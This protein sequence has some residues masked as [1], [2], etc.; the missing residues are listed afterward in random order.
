MEENSATENAPAANFSIA[1]M[2]D[3]GLRFAGEP[4]AVR[5]MNYLHEESKRYSR[6]L[7][8]KT[9]HDTAVNAIAHAQSII[10]AL[11]KYLN[12]Y[13]EQIKRDTEERYKQ[14]VRTAA[15]GRVYQ[16]LSEMLQDAGNIIAR[17]AENDAFYADWLPEGYTKTN[18]RK[19]KRLKSGIE[20][21]LTPDPTSDSSDTP[22]PLNISPELLKDYPDLAPYLQPK[23]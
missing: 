4:I 18:S 3:L 11:D 19:H 7:G 13:R 16:L 17:G 20:R 2:D 23:S 15:K 21:M 5:M 22:A 1:P 8:N 14:L 12:T 10:G 9:S 6:N